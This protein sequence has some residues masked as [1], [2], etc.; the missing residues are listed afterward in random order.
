MSRDLSVMKV[1]LDE[2]LGERGARILREGGCDVATVVAQDLC[3]AS[4][5]TLIEVCRVE[6]RTLVSLDKDFTNTLRYRPSRYAGIVVLRLPE[7]LRGDDIDEALRR[8][9]TLISERDPCGC[10]WIV[11][12]QRIREF[13][14]L[15]PS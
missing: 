15:E 12:S 4:D 6:G 3:S 10:L 8:L 2:N 13:V 14:E 7:P 11:D 1:K 9:L 5:D